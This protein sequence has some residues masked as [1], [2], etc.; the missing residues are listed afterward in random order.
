MLSETSL[1]EILTV[2]HGCENES[3]G[4]IS[5]VDIGGF[6]GVGSFL[7]QPG[8]DLISQSLLSFDG[9]SRFDGSVI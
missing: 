3:P 8:Y 2:S 6:V 4:V 5:Q 1:G 9:Q 7:R